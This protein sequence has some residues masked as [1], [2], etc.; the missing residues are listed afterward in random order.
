MRFDIWLPT[1]NPFATPE[2]LAAVARET[3][4]RGVHRIWVGEHL[5]VFDRYASRY[6]YA[7]DGR[8]PIPPGA[9]LLEPFTTLSFLAGLTHVARLGTAMCLLPQRNPVYTAKEVAT[10]DWLSAGRVDVGVGVGWLREEFEVAGVDW[11]RRGART[12]DYLA[13]L[14]AL[15]CDDPS[16]FSGRY[17]ELP[18]CSFHPKPVQDPHPPVHI[19]GESDAALRRA[20]RVGQGWHTFNRPPADL[21]PALARLDEL[22]DE[23]GRSRAD[24]EI[25]VCPY[26]QPLDPSI[27]EAYAAAGAD[28]V[29]ALLFAAS[30]EDVP[31]AFDLLEPCRQ[32]AASL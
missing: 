10:V 25:T 17:Y 24:L 9:G 30:A 29:A 6:P 32:R 5:V 22:L 27:T 28:A 12:D 2:F 31:A 18:E 20:A 21:P 26:F 4:A 13:V 16:S 19:G 14:T 7:P 1:A 23:A 8:M 3:E 15:W 11:D